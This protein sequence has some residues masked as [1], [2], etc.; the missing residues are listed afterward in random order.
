MS[1][2]QLSESKYFK[3][4]AITGGVLVVALLSFALGVRVGLHKALFSTRFGENYERNFL[5]WPEGRNGRMMSSFGWMMDADDR[6]VRNPH[7][8]SGE[9]ISLSGDTLVLKDRNNQESSI[10]ISPT[11]SINRGQETITADKLVVGDR[12][13]VVGRPGDDGVIV[14]RLIRVFEANTR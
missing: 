13:V 8:V 6:G 4:A 11:S 2:K 12:I 3:M 9:I 14:A 5:G 10:R 7:G 1:F